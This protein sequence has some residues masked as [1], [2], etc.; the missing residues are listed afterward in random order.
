MKQN[1]LCIHLTRHLSI[2]PPQYRE[3][4]ILQVGRAAYGR[5]ILTP[6]KIPVDMTPSNDERPHCKSS[7]KG[8]WFKQF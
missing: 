8:I 4:P 5:S 3:S 6:V 1:S 2:F 7:F